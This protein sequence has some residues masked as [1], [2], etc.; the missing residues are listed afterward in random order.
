MFL[1]FLKILLLRTTNLE[2]VIY[3]DNKIDK[4]IKYLNKS[5]P[6]KCINNLYNKEFPNCK[7]N[8][9]Y[10]APQLLLP[11]LVNDMDKIVMKILRKSKPKNWG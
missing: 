1:Q 6:R 7:G 3:E 2:K 9:I 11:A 10:V 5:A 4:R 8:V